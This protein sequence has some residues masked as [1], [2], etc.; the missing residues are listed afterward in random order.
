MSI[1][2]EASLARIITPHG[3]VVGAGFLI[4]E[5]TVITCAHVV[6][7]AL[8][9]ADATPTQPPEALV[10]LDFPLVVSDRTLTAHIISWQA[11]Q[12]NGGGDIAVLRLEDSP[13]EGAITARLVIADDLWDHSFRAFGFP[14][15]HDQGVWASGKLRAREATGWVQIEDVKITGKRIQQGFSGTAVWDEQLNGIV[16]MVVAADED[17]SKV[18]YL[19]PSYKLIQAWPVLAQQAIPPCPYRGLFAFREQD[20]PYFWGREIFSLELTDAVHRKPLVAIVG[21]SGSG[22]SSVIYAGL[23]PRL[24]QKENWLIASFRPGNRPFRSLAGALVSLLEPNMSQTDQ[25]LEINKLSSQLLQ[26]NLSLQD[27]IESLRERDPNTRLLLITDQFEEL[28]TQCRELEVRQRFL[29]ELLGTVQALSQQSKFNFHLLLSL[30]ADFVGQALSYRPFADALQYADIKL[31]PM[32]RYELLD[33]IR[34]PAQKLNVNIEDGLPERILDAISQGPGKLPLLEFTLT[35]LWEKQQERNLSHVVYNEIG[36]VEQALAAYAEEVYSNFEKEEQKLLQQIF[37]QLVHPGEGTEDSR[38]RAS[39]TELGE[40][41][42]CLVPRLSDT[43]LVVSARNSLTGEETVEVVHEALIREWQR[44]LGWI[45]RDRELRS[46][47]ER[48]R[49]ALRQWEMNGQDEGALLRGALL[50]EARRWVVERPEAIS[51]TEKIFIETS[52]QR[53]EEEVQLR[54]SYEAKE[55]KSRTDFALRLIFQSES[56]RNQRPDLQDVSMLL[57]VEAIQR[58]LPLDRHETLRYGLPLLSHFISP[59]IHKGPINAIIF[60]PDGKYL[61]TASTDGT[62]AVWEVKS[63]YQIDCMKHKANVNTIGFSPDGKYLA[64]ASEDGTAGIW[65]INFDQSII[66]THGGLVNAVAFSPDGKYLA[67]AST[68]R[69]AVVW[70]AI[71]G[72]QISRWSHKD[73]VK[74]VVFSPSD[75]RYLATASWDHTVKLGQLGQGHQHIKLSHQGRVNVVMFS[76]NGHYLAT[77]DTDGNAIIWDVTGC[78]Q[79]ACLTHHGPVNSVAFSFD[80]QYLATASADG[81]AMI[82]DSVKGEQITRLT[83]GRGINAVIFSPDGHYVVTASHDFTAEV[84]ETTSGHL[85]THLRHDGPVSTVAFS[86]DGRYLATAGWDNVAKIWPWHSE[87]IL[88]SVHSRLIRNLTPEEWAQYVGEEPYRKTHP[89]LP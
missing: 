55:R 77:A 87:Q 37:I 38:R 81:T 78:N 30:R 22:K 49:I 45:E 4:E 11:V 58:L 31:G 82:W 50:I 69:T 67:T 71:S 34:K 27:V 43:R 24:R 76:P 16:G 80:G 46:W 25:L 86:P 74:A 53:Y 3:T 7:A 42:W 41:L 35:L 10:S 54:K 79:L 13:P 12:A 51:L 9:I 33:A 40:S 83:H 56:L 23:I 72:D 62:A 2:L 61:A 89:D 20:A 68:N 15:Y 44:L 1:P 26:G 84:W 19:I 5:A 14:R 73:Y 59:L 32:N 63:G 36:G 60:S 17:T 64:T 8:G 47:Q 48:L 39:R 75:S 57:A 66:L 52:Q 21:A 6:T 28:Y 85:L 18:A 88:A 70:D 29:D 65:L